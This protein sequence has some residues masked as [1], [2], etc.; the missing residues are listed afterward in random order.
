MQIMSLPWRK[1]K[2]SL[3]TNSNV[4]K[5]SEHSVVNSFSA[6][7]WCTSDRLYKHS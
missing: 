5:H 6:T 7:R 1:K 4:R 2:H 3:T